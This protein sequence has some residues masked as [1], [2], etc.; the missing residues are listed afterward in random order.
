M[1]AKASALA[2]PL[3]PRAPAKPVD[4]TPRAI[5]RGCCGCFVALAAVVCAGVGRAASTIVGGGG[6]GAIRHNLTATPATLLP[7]GDGYMHGVSLGGWLVLEINPSKRSSSS[8][9]DVRPQWMFD[10]L[11]AASELDFVSGLRASHSDEYAI[12][13][14]KNHWEHYITDEMLDAAAALGVS[15]VRVPVGYWIVDACD[16]CASSLQ[17]GFSPEGF[18]T[19]GLNHLRR[20]LSRLRARGMAA[21][22]DVHALPCNSGCVSD[23]I[24]CANPLAFDATALVGDLARCTGACATVDGVRDCDGQVFPTTRKPAAQGDGGGGGGGGGGEGGGGV[25]TWG[26]VGLA[27]VGALAA[28]IAA[29]PADEA[30]AVVG[31]QL[32]NEPAL[33]TDGY[34]AAV[35]TYYRHALRRAR[36]S[37]PSLPLFLSFIPPND[38]GVPAF[39]QSLLASEPSNQGPLIVDHHW[40]L[41]WASPVGTSLEWS[42]LHRRACH[43]AR[44]SWSSYTAAGVPGWSKWPSR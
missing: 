11:E 16:G 12:Q 7:A 39:V 17:Y 27:S 3:L 40:Y 15:A 29:L 32:A 23:G 6:G 9:P 37:L 25:R 5:Y 2:E 30:A 34:D 35:K 44:Q 21:L 28:W 26:D 10:E 14:M 38:L 33:N 4:P 22:I 13:T 20:M 24:D 18:V 36:A 42:D 19:G 43:E 41:N 1:P 31:L 8:S